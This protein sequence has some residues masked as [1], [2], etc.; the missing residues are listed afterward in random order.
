MNDAKDSKGILLPDEVRITNVGKF[1]RKTSLDELPQIINVLTGDMS[2][3]GPRPLLIEYLEIYNK[4]EKKRHLV[5][6]GMTGWA[7]INGRNAIS[8]KKKFE[9]DVY[10]VDNISFLLDVDIFIKSFK[11][12][13][14][15][16]DISDQNHAT[17]EK[18][19]GK[20]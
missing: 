18:F 10:Y 9:L 1:V 16:N 4:T 6:P 8:W 14:K 20:N 5:E 19:N 7:Q 3:I 15:S 12:V 13:L 17:K 2:F 11:K